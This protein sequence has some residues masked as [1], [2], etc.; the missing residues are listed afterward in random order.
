MGVNM[1]LG[2]RVSSDLLLP[3]CCNCSLPQFTVGPGADSITVHNATS[4]AWHMLDTRYTSR[5]MI[6]E[7]LPLPKQIYMDFEVGKAAPLAVQVFNC[8]DLKVCWHILGYTY[9]YGCCV[10]NLG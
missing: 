2:S 8:A 6:A 7:P 4:V 1:P 10:L 5:P 3:C 9:V